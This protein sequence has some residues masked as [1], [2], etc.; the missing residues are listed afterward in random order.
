MSSQLNSQSSASGWALLSRLTGGGAAAEPG[1]VGELR[2]EPGRA[3]RCALSHGAGTRPQAQNAL[4]GRRLT[5]HI[6]NVPLLQRRPRSPLPSWMPLP[7][8]AALLWC[9]FSVTGGGCVFRLCLQ[10]KEAALRAPAPVVPSALVGTE[11][12]E[13]THSDHGM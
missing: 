4:H 12:L 5:E 13:V 11:P 9:R 7:C 1:G 3:E 8:R 2:E 6:L 10:E